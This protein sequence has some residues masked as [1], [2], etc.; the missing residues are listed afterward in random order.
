MLAIGLPSYSADTAAASQPR[1]RSIGTLFH[2]P[3]R[4]DTS[5]H[6]SATAGT[7]WLYEPA[8]SG[9]LFTANSVSW[10]WRS[11]ATTSVGRARD[12]GRLRRV[13]KLPGRSVSAGG[14]PIPAHHRPRLR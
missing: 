12:S 5:D 1:A 2:T 3:S 8:G 9:A 7:I 6:L 14:R 4:V 11:R 10:D 13:G